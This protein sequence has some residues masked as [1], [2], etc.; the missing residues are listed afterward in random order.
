MNTQTIAASPP[1][2]QAGLPVRQR[3][4]FRSGNEAAAL[5][6]TGHVLGAP[7]YRVAGGTGRAAPTDS[8]P[9][10]EPPTRSSPRS[11]Y[12][13]PSVSSAVTSSI[14]PGTGRP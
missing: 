5:A 2:P 3:I 14:W 4:E 12:A 11:V 7:G 6:W 10:N 8:G 13:H 9:I 1:V